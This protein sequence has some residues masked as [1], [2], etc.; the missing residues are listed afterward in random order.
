MAI[1]NRGILIRKNRI[2][3]TVFRLRLVWNRRLKSW[4]TPIKPPEY[5]PMGDTKIL[6]AK[7]YKKEPRIHMNT[8]F[9]SV[10]F[11]SFILIPPFWC[12]FA[13]GERIFLF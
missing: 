8:F 10:I 4:Q 3:W 11:V 2:L 1:K 13:E 9:A 6:T 12:S 5:R 7:Q